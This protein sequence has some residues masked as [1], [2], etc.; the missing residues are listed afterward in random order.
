MFMPSSPI[1]LQENVD[2]HNGG[3]AGIMWRVIGGIA[4]MLGAIGVVL[5]LLP[6]TPFVILA[7]FAFAKSSPDIHRWMMNNG[8]FGPIIA[9]W[10][11]HGAIAPRYKGLALATMGAALALSIVASVAAVVLTV[12]AVC[13]IAAA[14]FILSRPSRVA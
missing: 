2:R 5:P 10:Q 3:L 11:A 7:A 8:T 6:T 13:M 12:Q 1:I 4:L 14:I 9:D